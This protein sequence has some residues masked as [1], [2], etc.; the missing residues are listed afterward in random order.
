[1]SLIHLNSERFGDSDP[2]VVFP[3]Y[4][5]NITPQT[6]NPYFRCRFNINPISISKKKMFLKEIGFNYCILTLNESFNTHMK[7]YNIT[8]GTT[9]NYVFT[10]Q[11]FSNITDFIAYL[12]ATCTDLNFVYNSNPSAGDKYN[13]ITINHVNP[14]KSYRLIFDSKS[15]F[16]LLGFYFG[17][18]SNIPAGSTVTGVY[19]AT[20]TPIGTI[21][22]SLGL[23]NTNLS[24][25]GVSFDY[26]GVIEGG[27]DIEPIAFG[28]KVRIFEFK[29]FTQ[30]ID[31]KST[32]F[33]QL[34]LSFYDAYANY[35]PLNSIYTLTFEL[36]D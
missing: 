5:D 29:S 30:Y 14:L 31:I 35:V 19:N 26:I 34:Y 22:V 24:N 18:S 32:Q 11:N 28:Q 7:Y 6:F 23:P 1:M 8:D 33:N 15:I 16:R 3:S 20:L 27:S 9:H 25:L 4:I 21:Y 13:R 17:T 2:D 10:P 12:N 36:V